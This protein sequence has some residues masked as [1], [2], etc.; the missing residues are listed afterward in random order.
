M[1]FSLPT[2]LSIAAAVS[3]VAAHPELHNHN[4]NHPRR[5]LNTRAP[6]S[7]SKCAAQISARREATLT[8]RREALYKRRLEAMGEE[9]GAIAARNNLIDR[10]VYSTIQNTTCVLAPD[11]IFGPYGV[12][13]E[14]HRHDVREDSKGVDLY[15]D[16]GVIDTETCEPLPNAW[17]SI[18]SCNATG[19][20]ASYTGI[21]PNTVSV[22]DGWT[23]RS[24]GTTDDTTFLRGISKTDTDGMTEFLTIFPGYYASRTTHIHVTVQTNVSGT[25][26]SYS[27][28]SVQHVGQ[29]FFQES[30]I[31]KVYEL[32]PY[33]A[34]L[35]TLNRTTNSEDSLMSVANAD[36]YSAMVST[37][38]LGD[39][40]ED[41]LVGYITVGVNSTADAIAVTGTDVNVQGWLPTVSLAS[42]AQASASAIDAAAGYTLK[43]N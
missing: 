40:L 41:G 42:G 12:D 29:I 30:L 35:S 6:S 9:K 26:T 27:N 36:G 3:M 5:Q 1:H 23:Q 14:L 21:D 24:D 34:H 10:N 13:G 43:K 19:T 33:K 31:N 11:T 38:M 22:L 15:L 28:A 17:L 37:A 7:S 18:W 4:H 16:F 8:K 25:D 20:Y 32:S 2:I 39:S